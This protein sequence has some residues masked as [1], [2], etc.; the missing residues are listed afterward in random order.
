MVES[1]PEF[2]LG[3]PWQHDTDTNGRHE[4]EQWMYDWSAT[5]KGISTKLYTVNVDWILS[6]A[7]FFFY[8]WLALVALISQL[9]IQSMW[10][11]TPSEVVRM[12]CPH[13]IYNKNALHK[14][15]LLIQITTCR[16]INNMTRVNSNCWQ[17]FYW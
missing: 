10:Q 14:Y 15:L 9:Q 3:L 13:V 7:P 6:K 16:S 8:I 5:V 1:I 4:S 17:H 2:L 12:F 11:S